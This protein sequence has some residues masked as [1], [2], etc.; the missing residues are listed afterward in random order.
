MDPH[1]HLLEKY[2]V[3]ISF[4]IAKKIKQSQISTIRKKLEKQ[5]IDPK[6]IDREIDKE[7]KN[8]TER[9]I[10]KNSIPGM[11]SDISD[12]KLIIQPKV[13]QT[14]LIIANKIVATYKLNNFTKEHVIF[15]IQAVLHLLKITNDDM[16]KFKEK[17]N[18][19]QES[20]D[21]YLDEEGENEEPGF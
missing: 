19:G 13:Q 16:A 8:L 6:K 14:I 20:D 2:G 17:Y 15:L 1:R 10:N 5:N 4:D 21:D 18:I 11:C 12:K 7:I 9:Y 3:L